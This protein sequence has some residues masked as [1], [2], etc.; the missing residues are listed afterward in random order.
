MTSINDSLQD[1]MR[2]RDSSDADSRNSL[3]ASI[4]AR[5]VQSHLREPSASDHDVARVL[6]IVSHLATKWVGAF[7]FGESQAVGP[8]ALGLLEHLAEPSEERQTAVVAALE[9]VLLLLRMA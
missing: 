6:M 3:L 9:Q 1:L 5:L 4:L 7:G 2:A 8:T